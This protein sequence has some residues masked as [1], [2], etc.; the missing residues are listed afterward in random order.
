MEAHGLL[1]GGLDV[2]GPPIRGKATTA[3][4]PGSVGAD[5]TGPLFFLRKI[6]AGAKTKGGDQFLFVNKP[7]LDLAV[8]AGAD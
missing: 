1:C 5:V 4:L 8:V 6:A 7:D 2:R 3:R